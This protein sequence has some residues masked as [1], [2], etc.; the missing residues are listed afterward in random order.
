MGPAAAAK[1]RYR[2]GLFEADA[3]EGSLSKQGRAV[4]LQDQPFQ[5]LIALLE[6]HGEVVSR[7]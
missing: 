3:G 7:E 2:F 4:R 6:R 5:L 1:T